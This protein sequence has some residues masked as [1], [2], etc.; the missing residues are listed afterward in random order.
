M[1]VREGGYR[2]LLL[3]LYGWP[4]DGSQEPGGR[5]IATWLQS[6]AP[7]HTEF[8]RSAVDFLVR[9]HGRFL[10]RFGRLKHPQRCDPGRTW[11]AGEQRWA[12]PPPVRFGHGG[13]EENLSGSW[14]ASVRADGSVTAGLNDGCSL[15]VALWSQVKQGAGGVLGLCFAYL[16]NY[17]RWFLFTKA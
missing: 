7:S 2:C 13:A 8:E 11:R 14:N 15:T 4:Q 1:H 10:L 6:C 3:K 17:L 5:R 16:W 9:D 12:C